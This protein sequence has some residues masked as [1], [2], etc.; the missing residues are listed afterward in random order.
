MLVHVCSV[1]SRGGHTRDLHWLR[2][3]GCGQRMWR[4]G[5][6]EAKRRAGDGDRQQEGSRAP[7]S[8]DD[9]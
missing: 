4:R 2:I 5:A 7:E 9:E 6:R 1:R 3:M 8:S